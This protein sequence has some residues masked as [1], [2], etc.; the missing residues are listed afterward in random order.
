MKRNYY[1]V[2]NVDMAKKLQDNLLAAKV[3]LNHI[4][5]LCK[6]D[7]QLQ[8]HGL[9]PLPFSERK[10]LLADTEYGAMFGIMAGVFA[11][12][13]LMAFPKGT[14]DLTP[15]LMSSVSFGIGIAG[16]VIGFVIGLMRENYHI[17]E[18]RDQML[19]TQCIVM[20][21]LAKGGEKQIEQSLSKSGVTAQF[22]KQDDDEIHFENMSGELIVNG[23]LIVD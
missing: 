1:L 8:V 7:R 22:L 17:S 23:K 11:A 19:A 4:H 13:S 20:I 9:N 2:Q 6:D 14:F 10:D 3:P 18:F 16:A 21:D 15:I 5:M 12:I